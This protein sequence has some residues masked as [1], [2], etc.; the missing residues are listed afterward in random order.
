[1]GHYRISLMQHGDKL[2]GI[3][4]GLEPCSA[5]TIGKLTGKITGNEVSF[6]IEFNGK[7]YVEFK[8]NVSDDFSKIEGSI[9]YK[10]SGTSYTGEKEDLSLSLN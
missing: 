1:V 5:D 7:E 10:E 6:S 3:V 8:G 4:A 9:E 2:I